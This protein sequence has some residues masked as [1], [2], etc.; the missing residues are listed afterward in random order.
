MKTKTR[1]QALTEFA[2]ILPLLLLLLLGIIEGAR[3]VWAYITVQEAAREGARYAVSGRPYNADGD[4]WTFGA[5]ISDGRDGLCLQG[6]DDFGTCD[7]TDPAAPDAIDRV[8]AIS[9]MVLKR[10]YALAA[11]RYALTS[12]VYTATG[13]YDLPGTLGVRVV[14]QTGE[15]DP[16]TPDNAGKEGLNVL[17]QV[18]YNIE[19]WDPIYDAIVR[20][21]TGRSF[22]QLRG[23]V[24]MQNEGVEALLGSEPPSGIS[25]PL[26]PPGGSG[27]G[28]ETTSPL[29]LSPDGNS[30]PANSTMR[31]RLEQHTPGNY[32]DIYLDTI[33]ICTNIEANQFGI[34]DV[35]CQ[36]PPDFP[37][38]EDYELYSTVHGGSTKI[39]G[40]VF[41]DVTRIGEPTLLVEDGYRWP[42]GTQIVIQIRSHDA[43]AWYDL[44]FNGGLIGTVQ[45]DEFGDADFTWTIPSDTPRRVEPD[46]PY[47]LETL[48]QGTTSPIIANTGIY[49]TIPQI[50]VQG[51]NTWPAGTTLRANLRDH[52]PNRTY[53]VRCNGTSVGSF[54][55]DSQGR[56]TATIL[57]T[58]PSDAPNS[59]PYYTITSYDNGVLV[60]QVDVTISTPA[61]PYLVIIGGYDWPAG[62]PIDI[63][64]F[65]HQPNHN[66]RLYFENWVV[67]DSITTDGSGFAQT[68]YVIPITATQATT[69]TLRSYDLST[70]Q[71]VATQEV[72]VRAVPQISVTEGSIVQ[73]GSTIH[74]NLTRHAA[75]QV[76][77]I[78]L[79]GIT[80]ASIQTDNNGEASLTYDLSE[81]DLT[82]GPF[83]LESQLGGARVAQTDLSIV[84]A[85]LE[86]V[87]IQVPETPVFNTEMP[88][89]LTVRNNSSVAIS[90]QWFDTDIYVDPEHEPVVTEAFPPGNFKLWLDSLAPGETVTLVQNVVLYGANDHIVYARTNTSKYVLESDAD[91]PVNNMKQVTIA[92]ASCAA[93]IDEALTTDTDPD[94][95]FDP[96]WAGVAFGNASPA[97]ESIS[98]DVI[99]ITSQGSS[100]VRSDDDNGGYYLFYQEVSGN[101][102]ISVRALSQS[103]FSGIS[104]WAKFGLEVRD[105]TNSNARKVYLLKTRTRNIQW[106]YRASDGGSVSR[107]TVSGS[108]N[109]LPVWLRIVRIGD[110]FSL[111]YTYSSNTPPDDADWIYWNTYT[112]VMSDPVLI[113]MVN[114]SYSGTRSNTVTFDNFHACLDPADASGCGEVREENGTVVVDATNYTQNIS[115]GGHDWQEVTID[116]R[117]VMRALP[118]S[119]TNNNTGYT[120][121]SPELQYTVNIQTPGD[122]YVWVYAAGPNGYG[123]SLHVGINGT[124]NPESDRMQLNNNSTLSWTNNTM[125]GVRAVIRNVSTGVNTINVW[126][127]EDGAWFYKILLTTDP[128]YTPSGDV[129]QSPCAVSAGDEPFPPGMQ[130]CTPPDAPLLDNGD[131]EDNP[132]FQTAWSFNGDGTNISSLNPHGG[133]LSLRMTTWEN[134]FRSP[135]IW[136]EFTMADWITGTTTMKL[137]LWTSVNDQGSAEYTDTLKVELRTTGITPTVISTPTIVARGDQGNLFPDNYTFGEWDLVPAMQAVGANPINY[138]GQN[139]QLYFYDD[140][141]DPNCL[142]F[143]PG[144]YWTDFYLDDLELEICTT[145]PIP[146]LDPTKTTI[147]GALRVMLGGIPT[148][149]QGVRVWAYMQNG[150]MYTTYSIHDSSYGFYNI[151][152]GEYV[153]YAEWWEG[154]DLY[155]AVNT[156]TAGAGVEYNVPLLLQ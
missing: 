97:S 105:S 60:A 124:E 46:P 11:Q 20:G 82:G 52:A 107:G 136:Q 146:P 84:A 62:S 83:I 39:A 117:R 27:D 113:G 145:Q 111:Y 50:V 57:C 44:Y 125:D 30:F 6:V 66:Y 112:V 91:N 9:N 116:G 88:I 139:L 123:D 137:R 121:N 138:A 127:R 49:V 80:L 78:L 69:Y 147:K 102:D 94:N 106:G 128:N 5:D 104:S 101:F 58:I 108:T 150:P 130:V 61:E 53:E 96:N 90:G 99:S 13:Y 7:T 100:T 32:Y 63:Q 93:T 87:S 79:D 33:A 118:D 42:R 65:Q 4:P 153:I 85:D 114:A 77:D 24:L 21:V 75:N 156:V 8:D 115:R 122:Y 48:E 81:L 95:A 59:P 86:L 67:I 10:A 41:V 17:V 26:P 3:I 140:S 148:P 14:G 126:M 71:T 2:L 132:G 110:D 144:C 35:N 47:A 25:A 51:G 119:G 56:S 1:G 76:Y 72:T 151:E 120:T 38:G 19:M 89:T 129:A 103:T 31:V 36:I 134:G 143:G 34:A 109:N 18:Y 22:V 64:V 73:P 142:D 23:E 28:G 155:T 135:A 45:V 37:P 149:K 43:H 12:Q 92:P 54:T 70:S 16:G 15:D 141:N 55:T 133:N 152:P 74:I 68:A 154:P 40:G 29:I 98:N 131:V